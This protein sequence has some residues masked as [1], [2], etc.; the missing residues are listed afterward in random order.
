MGGTSRHSSLTMAGLA[1]V[2][3]TSSTQ[4]DSAFGGDADPYQPPCQAPCRH[5]LC[6]AMDMAVPGGGAHD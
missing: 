5:H 6:E 2:L 3:T 4:H 1:R